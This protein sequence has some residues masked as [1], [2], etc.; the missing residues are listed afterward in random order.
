MIL[1]IG[2]ILILAMFAIAG[3][4][5][6]IIKTGVSLVGT[7]LIFIISFL[8]KGVIGN[9]LCKYLPFFNLEGNYEGL[10]SINILIYQLIGFLVIFA[11]LLSIYT[12]I[13]KISKILDKAIKLTLVFAIPSKILGSILGII[14]GY[15]VVFV[16]LV[17]MMIPLHNTEIF[18]SSKIANHIIYKS[19]ILTK[20]SSPVTKTLEETYQLGDK[21]IKKKISKKEANKKLLQIMI[22]NKV[23]NQ[24]LVDELIESKKL[25]M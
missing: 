3:F 17:V 12:V 18:T 25:K 10:S 20:L 16:C 22:K 6:G 7:L 8:L 15:I 24:K 21:I 4:K 9:L 1:N 5:E 13:I 2:I 19:P 11:I 14:E 23:V